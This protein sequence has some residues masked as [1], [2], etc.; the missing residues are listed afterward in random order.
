MEH[1]LNSVLSQ[2]REKHFKLSN[3]DTG[4]RKVTIHLPSIQNGIK[5]PTA[6][7]KVMENG[8]F[9]VLHS[10]AKPNSVITGKLR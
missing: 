4:K 8:D 7:I 9:Q 1:S 5:M 3:L 10:M 6:K 2:E